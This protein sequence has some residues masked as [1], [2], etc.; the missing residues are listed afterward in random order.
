MHVRIAAAPAA[1]AQGAPRAHLRRGAPPQRLCTVSGSFLYWR[2]ASECVSGADCTEGGRGWAP[3]ML[4]A[5]REPGRVW[6]L[7]RWTEAL[8][9]LPS[10]ACRPLLGRPQGSALAHLHPPP[11]QLHRSWCPHAHCCLHRLHSAHDQ[12]RRPQ[13]A[14]TRS[15]Q[16][17]PSTPLRRCPRLQQVRFCSL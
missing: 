2:C 3:P 7:A 10:P 9:Q 5:G 4:A 14:L 17:A 11:S 16:P 8:F 6:R 12:H 13:L 15:A 1:A